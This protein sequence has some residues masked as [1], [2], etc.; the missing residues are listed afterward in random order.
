MLTIC[1]RADPFDG[2]NAFLLVGEHRSFTQAA[3]ALGV[4]AA[5]VSQA[6]RRLELRLRLPLFQRTSRKVG[7]TEA[8][9]AL[10][11]LLHPAAAQIAEALDSL[12][13]FRERPIGRLRITAPRIALPLVIEPVLARFRAGY[14]E[15]AVEIDVNDASIDLAGTNCDAGIRFGGSVEGDMVAVRLTRDVRW[16]VFGS[17]SYLQ[18]KGVP[19]TPEDLRSHEA[20]LYRYPS[21]GALQQWE[22]VRAKRRIA[23]DV[24][25]RVI[26]TDSL[27]L[28]SMARRGLGLIYSAD[29][30]AEEDVAA[31]RLR[32]VLERYW[33]RT[34]GLF[35]YFPRRM[36]SQRKLRAFIDAAVDHLRRG[37]RSSDRP[38]AGERRPTNDR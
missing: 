30:V 23:V 32:P 31:E 36:Q 21:S 25:A 10:H 15:I 33:R 7:L 11:R 16:S 38:S 2:L 35:L 26:T 3:R 5:A 8:G 13:S 9:V 28:L 4:S 24:P 17:P 22:F 27:S 14:P 19:A 20:I 34:P 29:L 12:N 37:R 6:I 18:A 1:M